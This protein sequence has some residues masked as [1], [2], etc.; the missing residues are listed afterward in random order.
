MRVNSSADSVMLIVFAFSDNLSAENS[1]CLRSSA[2]AKTA[3]L[4]VCCAGAGAAYLRL[5]VEVHQGEAAAMKV[6][7]KDAK[8]KQF[9]EWE[10][11][12]RVEVEDE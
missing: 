10:K 9:Q 8:M 11:G 2:T 5:Q 1:N 12:R 3:F 7:A 4:D 6:D